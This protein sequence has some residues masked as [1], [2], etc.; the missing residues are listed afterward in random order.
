[1][2]LVTAASKGLG[3]ATAKA[4]A[5]EGARVMMASRSAESLRTAAERIQEETGNADVR[6]FTCDVS[7][8][9]DIDALFA[10]LEETYGTLHVLINNAGGPVPGTFDTVTEEDWYAAFELSLMSVVRCVRRALPLMRRNQ[11]GRIVNFA[12]SSVRQ[13]ID[14]LILSNTFRTAVAGLAKSLALELAKDNIL[15][16]T[17][18]P[19]RIATDRVAFLDAEAARRS[20][21]TVEEVRRRWESQI[22]LGRYGTPE[23]FAEVALFLGSPANGYV[24]GQTLLVDGG[25]VRS[26]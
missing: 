8:A 9:A 23:E 10:A 16:N 12:S 26:L 17:L 6:W 1:V 11:W 4:F 24:T 22:P 7:R 2:V 5:R 19:G 20:G 3:Y 13:P 14:N 25:M 18:G 15:V 21:S